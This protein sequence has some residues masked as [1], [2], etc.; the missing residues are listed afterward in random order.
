MRSPEGVDSWLEGGYREI[1][2]PER[3]VF[4]HVWLDA[5]RKPGKQTL[6]TISLSERDGKTELTCVRPA[7]RRWNRA[8]DTGMAGTARSDV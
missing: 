3:L 6:V 5:N 8:M 4:T 2:K 1:A 7:S